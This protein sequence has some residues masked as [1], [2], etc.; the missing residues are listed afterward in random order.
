MLADSFRYSV[1]HARVRAMMSSLLTA[2]MWASLLV[3]QDLTQ[4][5]ALLAD[6]PYGPY[7][8]RKGQAITPRHAA[9]E[10]NGRLAEVFRDIIAFAPESGKAL[11]E[12]LRRRFEVDNLKAILRGIEAGASPRQVRLV[13]FPLEDATL[14]PVEGM[15]GVETLGEAVGR[16]QGTKYHSTLT[17]AMPRYV[18]E[19]NLFP[20]EVALDLDYYRSLWGYVTHL[21]GLDRKW[22]LR[23]V[24]TRV[25][26]INLMWAVRY[27][28][29]HHLSEE[30]II[31][32]T[33]PYG[34]RVNDAM[35]R[36]IAAGGDIERIIT[37]AF[38]YA[39]EV[40]TIEDDPGTNLTLLESALHHHL[41]EECHS[42]FTGYPFHLGIP[43]GYVLLVELEVQDIT[44][45]IEAK[46]AKLSPDIL[47]LYLANR[48]Q[49]EAQAA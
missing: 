31:N 19:K 38:P 41:V 36:A 15:L 14:L 13:L 23:L 18:A 24:G 39:G 42:A 45:L 33:L 6:T 2:E 37:Q 34:L 21:S 17:H 25:D 11:F 47:R 4:L 44:L 28:V 20:L 22:A 35:I 12:Q 49:R 1:A 30:E 9:Y 10:A 5:L 48:I 16:L 27:R 26:I 29:Y 8:A 7:L 3:A 40:G 32:Y 43:L 46:A